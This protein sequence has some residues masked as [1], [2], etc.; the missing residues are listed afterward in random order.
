MTC[1]MYVYLV[2]A[3]TAAVRLCS[4]AAAGCDEVPR[5]AVV[6]LK[7]TSDRLDA[8]LAVAV[9]LLGLAALGLSLSAPR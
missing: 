4:A 9:L 6:V 1:I 8:V 7:R 3:M 2:F 5:M